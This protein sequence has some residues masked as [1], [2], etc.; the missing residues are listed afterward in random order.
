M[1]VYCVVVNVMSVMNK[2]VL[3]KRI[4]VCLFNDL[5]RLLLIGMYIRVFYGV[6]SKFFYFSGVVKFVVYLN[7]WLNLGKI[8]Y[9]Y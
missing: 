1:S 8:I 9:I 5:R 4:N 2:I 6:I 3:K 7:D